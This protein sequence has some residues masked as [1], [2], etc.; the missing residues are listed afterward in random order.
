M[1]ASIGG[2]I[3]DGLKNVLDAQRVDQ[4]LLKDGL[5][6]LQAEHTGSNAQF[7]LHIGSMLDSM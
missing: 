5:E 2:C 4:L 1:F 3:I 6:V 7:C